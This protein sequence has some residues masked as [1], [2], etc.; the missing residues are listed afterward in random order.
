MSARTHPRPHSATTGGVGTRLPWWAL[1]LPSFAFV[2]LLLLMLDPANARA[3]SDPAIPQF[4]VGLQHVVH[5][6]LHAIP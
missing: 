6:L 4:I 3:A 5:V 2:T 1:A